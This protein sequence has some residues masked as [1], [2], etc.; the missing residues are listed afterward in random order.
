MTIDQQ[1]IEAALRQRLHYDPATGILTWTQDV[2]IGR[3]GVRT[4]R[5]AGERAGSGGAKGYRTIRFTIDGFRKTYKE[6]RLIWF[7]AYG[8]W[9]EG[10]IDHI[11]GDTSDNRL[12][13]LRIATNGQNMANR[14]RRKPTLS[15][16]KGVGFDRRS[17]KYFARI[18]V[19]KTRLYKSCAT[20]AEAAAVYAEWA[21]KHFGE[22]ARIE[23]AET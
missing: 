9:P 21:R 5:K 13:N 19:N 18:Q 3:G 2:P 17:K 12:A 23:H 7:L 14:Q 15:G 11:N 10:H 22:F 4:Q 16:V 20:K 1:T 6:H 8:A